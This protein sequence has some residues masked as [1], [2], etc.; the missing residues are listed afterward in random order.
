MS[1]PQRSTTDEARSFATGGFIATLLGGILFTAATT[2]DASVVSRQQRGEHVGTLSSLWPFIQGVGGIALIVI[3]GILI[4]S[5]ISIA[6]TPQPTQADQ[7][8][9]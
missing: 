2:L 4:K 3:G 6:A 7:N 1:A 9:K 5:A 8:Q